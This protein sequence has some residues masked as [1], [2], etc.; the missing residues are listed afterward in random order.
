MRLQ[1]DGQTRRDGKPAKAAK[2]AKAAGTAV[3]RAT[4]VPR[5]CGT[6]VTVAAQRLWRPAGSGPTRR[7]GQ[8]VLRAMS[9]FVRPMVF[10]GTSLESGK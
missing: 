4:G 5:A 3:G 10:S 9:D 1:G 2:A 7:P 6:P 8:S